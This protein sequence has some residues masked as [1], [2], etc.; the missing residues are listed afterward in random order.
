MRRVKSKWRPAQSKVSAGFHEVDPSPRRTVRD[1]SYMISRGVSL[2][3]LLPDFFAIRIPFDLNLDGS[4]YNAI[5]NCF[6][7]HWVSNDLRP[8]S[9][10]KLCSNYQGLLVPSF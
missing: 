9:N 5:C 6:A 3:Q 10:W 7:C 8:I 4:S 1:A 2:S